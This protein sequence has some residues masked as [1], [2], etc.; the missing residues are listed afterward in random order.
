MQGNIVR[1]IQAPSIGTVCDLIQK[2]DI[3]KEIKKPPKKLLTRVSYAKLR[4][5]KIGHGY[6]FEDSTDNFFQEFTDHYNEFFISD[7]QIL[8][9]DVDL[10]VVESFEKDTNDY[11]GTIY[12]SEGNIRSNWK[13]PKTIHEFEINNVYAS[14]EPN[15]YYRLSPFIHIDTDSDGL[16]VY[17]QV[18][19]PLLGKIRYNRID[20]SD[21]N[22]SVCWSEFE[23]AASNGIQK[24]QPNGSIMNIF[25]ANYRKYIEVGS[26]K[27]KVYDFLIGKEKGSSVCI[28]LWGH[29]GNGKTAT[30][31]KVCEELALNDKRHFDFIIFLSAKDRELNKVT[32]RIDQISIENRVT[33]F[34]NLIEKINQIIYSEETIDYSRLLNDTSKCLIVIDDYETFEDLDKEKVTH[35]IKQLNTNYHKIILTTRNS[36]LKIGDDIPIN[37][38]DVQNTKKFLIEVLT[39]E[40]NYSPLQLFEVQES[41]K[42]NNMIEEIHRLTLGKPIEIIRFANCFIQKAKISESFI[43]Q[44]KRVISRSERIE[45]LYGRNYTQLAGDRMAQDIFVVIGLLTPKDT[46]TSLVKHIKVILNKKDEE[47]SKFNTALDKLVKLRLLEIDEDGSYKVDSKD[48]LEIMKKEFDKREDK[49]IQ[50]TISI[51][52]RI[53][54]NI[55]SDTDRALLNHVKRLRIQSNAETAIQQYKEILRQGKDFSYAVK[56]EAFLDLTDFLFNYRG[57]KEGAIKIF[58]EFHEQFYTFDAIKRYSNLCWSVDEAKS[59][60]ILEQFYL[61]YENLGLSLSTAARVHLLALIVFRESSF[62]N[63]RY[64]KIPNKRH[65]IKR[66]LMR[67][68]RVYGKIF[69]KEIQ[70]GELYSGLNGE[71]RNDVNLA[72]ENLIDVVY[73]L[74]DISLAIN[75]VQ[76]AI[77]QVPENFKIRF[78]KKFNKIRG[79]RSSYIPSSPTKEQTSVIQSSVEI[80]SLELKAAG[81][82][83]KVFKKHNDFVTNFGYIKPDNILGKVLFKETNLAH[84]TFEELQIGDYVEFGFGQIAPNKYAAINIRKISV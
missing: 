73:R 11:M 9:K 23:F 76:F 47:E 82:K 41:L 36:F 15:V 62:W 55:T 34:E 37:E 22:F 74:K 40:H 65:T 25:H 58:D 29:G 46:L 78:I 57:D 68:A 80:I 19:Q 83:G 12:D 45:F 1:D 66:E 6:S 72:L 51:Y 20:K 50:K 31:Q 48:I 71:Q 8:E 32:G 26:I 13:C 21:H 39:N 4:N 84:T 5:D 38:L 52:D 42:I 17:R 53:K 70:A 27:E 54:S 14:Y 59:I 10:I 64:D 33:S 81:Y 16:Y 77:K 67:I 79:Y 75:I 3:E 44:M 60:R 69:Y 35:F 61:N 63:D 30:A 18:Q 24:K 2:L 7:T 43:N 28:T 56:F 49:F